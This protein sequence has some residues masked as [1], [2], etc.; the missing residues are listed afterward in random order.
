MSTYVISWD[1][2]SIRCQY[3]NV[4][5]WSPPKKG[6]KKEKENPTTFSEYV[7]RSSSPW[8]EMPWWYE[9]KKRF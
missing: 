6:K 8:M 1:L 9:K 3:L 5:G 2:T 4:D 7:C